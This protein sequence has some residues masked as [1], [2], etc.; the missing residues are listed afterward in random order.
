MGNMW[1]SIIFHDETCTGRSAQAGDQV[2]RFG[3]VD[4]ASVLNCYAFSMGT[5]SRGG[6]SP[7]PRPFFMDAEE[8]GVFGSRTPKTY[9][10]GVEFCFFGAHKNKRI[11]VSNGIDYFA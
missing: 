10:A 6:S 7:T 2:E 11:C 8:T 9:L 3:S 1:N 4:A 5:S